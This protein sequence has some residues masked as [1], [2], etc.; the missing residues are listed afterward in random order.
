MM[1]MIVLINIL[2]LNQVL[3]AHY[4]GDFHQIENNTCSYYCD[5][6]LIAVCV[7]SSCIVLIICIHLII[8]LIYT[9]SIELNE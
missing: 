3:Q 8:F 7:V 1:L 9:S 6:S 2:M 5:Y 4:C